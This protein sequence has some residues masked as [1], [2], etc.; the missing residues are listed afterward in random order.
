MTVVPS[1]DVN[2]KIEFRINRFNKTLTIYSLIH[3]DGFPN[4]E[5][6]MEDYL[7]KKVFI[8]S[9]VRFGHP[10]LHL[11]G[12]NER[13]MTGLAIT[14]DL[15]EDGSFGENLIL[16]GRFYGGSLKLRES[17]PFSSGDEFHHN[18]NTVQIREIP[19]VKSAFMWWR[20]KGNAKSIGNSDF[21]YVSAYESY[22]TLE[23]ILINLIQSKNTLKR[24][25]LKDWNDEILHWN[26]NEG[27]SADSQDLSETKWG[28]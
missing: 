15:N 9:H 18:V 11:F 24:Y 17:Y 13:L 27:R 19:L 2:Q 5:S 25:S 20:Y 22:T 10:G 21:V 16:H 7:G 8:G 12:G 1:L 23:N 6:F 4:C 14:I 3:G 26:P 28:K